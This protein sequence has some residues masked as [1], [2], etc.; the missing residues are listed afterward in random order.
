[1]R[2]D[3][4]LAH[5]G[6]LCL[7]EPPEFSRHVLAVL[8]QPLETG[9]TTRHSCQRPQRRWTGALAALATN[10]PPATGASE[11]FPRRWSDSGLSGRAPWC[12]VVH[13]GG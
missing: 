7:D 10:L 12:S 13:G 1:M 5:N 6:V 8:R 9:V 3:V 11:Y 4:S 2:R